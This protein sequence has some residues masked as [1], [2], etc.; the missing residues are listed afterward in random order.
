M[1]TRIRMHG[2]LSSTLMRKVYPKTRFSHVQQSLDRDVM[3]NYSISVIFFIAIVCYRVNSVQV[4]AIQV[5]RHRGIGALN[6]GLLIHDD[7]M[8]LTRF[9]SNCHGKC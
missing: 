4:Y 2:R 9:K 8:N 3:T 1:F 6:G 7:K 5:G